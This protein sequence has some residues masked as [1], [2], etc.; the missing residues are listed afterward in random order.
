MIYL[1]IVQ[2]VLHKFLTCI[3][4][5]VSVA[6][7]RYAPCVIYNTKL[8]AIFLGNIKSHCRIA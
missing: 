1:S 5:L 3:C 2:Y 6:G 4:V 8:I 7:I